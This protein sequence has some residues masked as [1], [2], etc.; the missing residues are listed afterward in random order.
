MEI[1][2][3]ASGAFLALQKLPL[4][5]ALSRQMTLGNPED[6]EVVESSPG[7]SVDGQ[8]VMEINR[9]QAEQTVSTYFPDNKF[10]NYAPRAQEPVA[11]QRLNDRRP[12]PANPVQQAMMEDIRNPVKH[13][14]LG[15]TAFRPSWLRNVQDQSAA[16]PRQEQ[17]RKWDSTRPPDAQDN[18]HAFQHAYR[19]QST[20]AINEFGQGGIPENQQ[21]IA[22]DGLHPVA[23][24]RKMTERYHRYTLDHDLSTSSKDDGRIRG[25]AA[26]QERGG[27]VRADGLRLNPDRDIQM[28]SSGAAKLMN[29][30]IRSGGV[31][32]PLS[33]FIGQQPVEPLDN[34]RGNHQKDLGQGRKSA[35]GSFPVKPNDDPL[36]KRFLY[37]QVDAASAATGAAYASAI[38]S[39]KSFRDQQH[40]PQHRP[41]FDSMRSGEG[42]AFGSLIG[43]S[44]DRNTLHD[45]DPH[46]Q[47]YDA[48]TARKG[49]AFGSIISSNKGFRDTEVD[50]SEHV[51]DVDTNAASTN[52]AMH[53]RVMKKATSDAAEKVA[54][55]FSFDLK[56]LF[57]VSTANASVKKNRD[58][59]LSAPDDIRGTVVDMESDK[60]L[61]RMGLDT[62]KGNER[63]EAMPDKRIVFGEKERKNFSASSSKRR[64]ADLFPQSTNAAVYKGVTTFKTETSNEEK[65]VAT[66]NIKANKAQIT[67]P[68]G[69]DLS[70]KNVP[71]KVSGAMTKKSA[72]SAGML[73]DNDL[74]LE[75]G[76]QILE[77]LRAPK[78]VLPDYALSKTN[79]SRNVGEFR[80]R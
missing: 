4:G 51:A 30:G 34:M 63:I 2:L 73:Y 24:N 40:D 41:D 64:E 61:Q 12:I 75:R 15:A 8:A 26:G 27:L 13:A 45:V 10:Y 60:A 23:S 18:M 43:A 5:R 59:V 21:F 74:I 62:T 29:A 28:H 77:P 54:W 20:A 78:G 17:E 57:D 68:M 25:V 1:I 50:T 7:E 44:R 9:A 72:I 48:M 65:G 38:S 67:K 33:S 22:P 80:K 53:D 36:D 46:V 31:G 49:V 32:V 79:A 58:A 42:A 14:A 55:K 11:S 76:A 6:G 71:I 39:N 35:V 66:T 16:Q 19:A 37:E 56:Q 47:D 70:G 52:V 69:A 3:L